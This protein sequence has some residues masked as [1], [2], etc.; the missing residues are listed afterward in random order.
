MKN[1]MK[2]TKTKLHIRRVTRGGR[3]DVFPTLFQKLEKSVPIWR[4][5]ALIVVIYG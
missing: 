3:G 5:D 4:K 1:T 2:V